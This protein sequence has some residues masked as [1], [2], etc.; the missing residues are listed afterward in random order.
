MWSYSRD[1]RRMYN[2]S[3]QRK[4]ITKLHWNRTSRSIFQYILNPSKST[5]IQ[6]PTSAP[7]ST[8]FDFHQIP[9]AEAIKS[10]KQERKHWKDLKV[11]QNQGNFYFPFRNN[12][13]IYYLNNVLPDSNTL[14][15]KFST[16][17]WIYWREMIPSNFLLLR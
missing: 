1:L 4:I 14:K 3:H 15:E 13:R 11:V 6:R 17:T 16:Q 7:L 8:G 5:A 9:N 12:N 10:Y 2:F